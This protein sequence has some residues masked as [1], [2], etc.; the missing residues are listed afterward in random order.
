MG[1]RAK[2]SC[3]SVKLSETLAAS[4]FPVCGR[5]GESDRFDTHSRDFRCSRD[6][7]VV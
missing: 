4:E 1:L 5:P 2:V 6:L 7:S 3:Q